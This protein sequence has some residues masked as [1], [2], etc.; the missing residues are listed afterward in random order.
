MKNYRA[1]G[2]KKSLGQ[3]AY[4]NYEIFDDV[5]AAYSDFF[6]KIMT[7]IASF[8][9][10]RVKGNT[11]KW[12]DREALEILNSRDKFFFKNLKSLDHTFTKS[13]LR[14]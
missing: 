2:Y 4:P 6:Q 1:D 9:T 3:L 7:V 13:Y 5:N 8:K 12:F 10:K 14:K 11:Q